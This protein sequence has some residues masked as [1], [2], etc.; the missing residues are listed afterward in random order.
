LDV[1]YH[2]LTEIYNVQAHVADFPSR[3]TH[4]FQSY[5]LD[6][7]CLGILM[8][9]LAVWWGQPP[10]FYFRL[11]DPDL[12]YPSI[13]QT[14]SDT[15]ITLVIIVGPIFVVSVAQVSVNQLLCCTSYLL[16]LFF[17]HLLLFILP[18]STFF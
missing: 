8:A 1:S 5:L 14:I 7:I 2:E 4:L 11:D 12:S 17:L 18:S 13:P 6:W 15:S 3:S 9:L 16:S 10:K